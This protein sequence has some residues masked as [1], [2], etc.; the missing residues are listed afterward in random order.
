MDV[1]LSSD[2]VSPDNRRLAALCYLAEA[3]SFAREL[4]RDPW[5]FAV[6][7]ETFRELGLTNNEFRW[8]VCKGL[9]EHKRE[10][11]AV[12]DRCRVF[13]PDRPLSFS[14]GACFVIS[15]A[16]LVLARRGLVSSKP[17]SRKGVSEAVDSTPVVSLNVFAAPPR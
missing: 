2:H 16:G 14:E 17:A 8:L 5:D 4:G 15:E 9:V 1:D 3:A 11:T 12:G 13:A 7:I 6:E 10:T